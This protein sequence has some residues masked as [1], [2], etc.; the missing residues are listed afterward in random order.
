MMT[1]PIRH[2]RILGALLAVAAV[3]ISTAPADV[4]TKDTVLSARPGQDIYVPL[5]LQTTAGEQVAGINGQMTFDTNYFGAPQIQVGP[6]APGFTI[7]GNEVSPGKFRFVVYADPTAIMGLQTP[8]MFVRLTAAGT[9]PQDGSTTIDFL[10][11][12]VD[13]SDPDKAGE[14]AAATQNGVSIGSVTFNSVTVALNETA[15]TDWVRYE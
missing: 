15:A 9:L 12:P 2:L 4:T 7:L 3:M 11:G 1:Q 5:I 14:S 6:A 13:T 8:V 10:N